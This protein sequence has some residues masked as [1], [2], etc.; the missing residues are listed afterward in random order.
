M[1]WRDTPRV[2][3]LPLG[4]ICHAIGNEMRQR[5][6][7]AMLQLATAAFAEVTAW[8]LGAVRPGLQ[9][10]IRQQPVTRSSAGHM[11]ARRRDAIAFR[12]NTQD[13]FAAQSAHSAA[14]NRA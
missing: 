1:R 7:V 14:A 12:G 9:S 10:A 3:P 6:V 5:R 13:R 2:Q 11:P 4:G 8:R